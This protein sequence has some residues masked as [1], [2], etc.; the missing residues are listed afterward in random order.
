MLLPYPIEAI[1]F[2]LDG[3]ILDTENDL[4]EALNYIL[5][6]YRFPLVARENYRPVASD[7]A[8]GLLTLGFGD[9]LSSY[10]YEELRSEFLDYYT[11]NI[12]VHTCLYEGISE[13]IS[14]IEQQNIPWGIVTNKPEGL[15]KKLL[16]HFSELA[17]CSVM[18]AGDTLP[19]RKPHPAPMFH[20]C[21]QIAVAPENCVYI[22][23]APRD[24]D[25]G[26]NAN[27]FTIVALWGY[28][29]DKSVCDHWQA[30]IQTQHPKEIIDVIKNM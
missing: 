7:G 10:N 26:N 2:D 1:L 30:D 18:V 16:P 24:I 23:D 20:A 21:K 19:E 17:K 6:K 5:A 27:M 13:L 28:I 15:T 8:L 29:F 3:P 22:G 12:A 14:Y 4:G 11:K 25:A 9:K